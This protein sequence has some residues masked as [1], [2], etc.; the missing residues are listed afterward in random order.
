MSLYLNSTASTTHT[1]NNK[2]GYYSSLQKSKFIAHDHC[3]TDCQQRIY[4]PES[5]GMKV[6]HSHTQHNFVCQSL[7][8]TPDMIIV[9]GGFCIFLSA[10]KKKNIMEVYIQ[11]PF[12]FFK[13]QWPPAMVWVT[14]IHC[15]NKHTKT[16]QNKTK[17]PDPKFSLCLATSIWGKLTKARSTYSTTDTYGNQSVWISTQD[18]SIMCIFFFCRQKLS[19][20]RPIYVTLLISVSKN[21]TICTLVRLLL[22]L[23]YVLQPSCKYLQKHF[24]G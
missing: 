16:H 24:Q 20:E 10:G 6:W 5:K 7:A 8:E 11:V 14:I 17:K 15:F 19:K 1:I 21:A 12:R 22:L 23:L 4:C 18:T 9:F 2:S 3:T 13:L